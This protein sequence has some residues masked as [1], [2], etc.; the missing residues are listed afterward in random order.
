MRHCRAVRRLRQ[1]GEQQSAQVASSCVAVGERSAVGLNSGAT[2][3]QSV[4]G[5]RRPTPP[6]TAD[7]KSAARPRRKILAT[8]SAVRPHARRAAVRSAQS[9]TGRG[10]GQSPAEGLRRVASDADN[11]IADNVAPIPV[12]SASANLPIAIASCAPPVD[13]SRLD[14]HELRNLCDFFLTL[15]RWER[16]RHER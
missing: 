3:S 15:D 8:A 10:A 7:R 6:P 13:W 12:D 5:L 1:R 14:G 4:P 16:D 9:K 11:P 2:V